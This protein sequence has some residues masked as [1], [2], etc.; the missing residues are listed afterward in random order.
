M[1]KKILSGMTFIVAVLFLVFYL[2]PTTAYQR[3]DFLRLIENTDQCLI[4]CYAIIEVSNPTD[5]D[6]VLDE[7]SWGLWHVKALGARGLDGDLRLQLQE[8]VSYEVEVDDYEEVTESLVCDGEFG[9]KGNMAWCYSANGNLTWNRSFE[10]IIPEDKKIYQTV[11]K[12]VSSHLEKKTKKKYVDFNPAGKTLKPGETY[13]IKILGKKK[14]QVG[15]NNVDWRIR[16]LDFEPDWAWWNSSWG[17]KRPIEINSTS[18]LSDYQ[19]AINVTYDFDMQSDFDDLRFINEEETQ[20]LD[21][22]VESKSDGNWAYVWVEIDSID[23]NNGTQAHMYYGNSGATFKSNGTNTFIQYHGSNSDADFW[24]GVGISIPFIYE[25][26]ATGSSP[27]NCFWGT[28]N[29]E[30]R[31]GDD[32]AWIQSATSTG[33]SYGHSYN[34]GVKTECEEIGTVGTNYRLKIVVTSTKNWFYKNDNE[35]AS[36]ITTNLPNENLGLHMDYYSG[37]CSQTWCFAR[38]YTSPE[39]TYLIGSEETGE[40]GGNA[41]GG[42]IKT[43]SG[44]ITLDPATGI[45]E[46]DGK[47]SMKSP[48]GSWFCCGPN[49]NG[50]WTCS[51]GKCI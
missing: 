42:T 16:F 23:T 21:Y 28:S 24:E 20:E 40:G 51:A 35:I 3:S 45:V 13:R 2:N 9:F 7:N 34:E 1:N 36:G 37:I 5:Q 27:H 44:N 10:A 47:L 48:N 8:D 22:W 49:D 31:G 33:K 41:T 50:T 30:G 32:G 18:N 29:T 46:I 26:L 11:K 15:P 43:T 39:P 14:A 12:K 4:D 17:Y 25:V 6:I 38:K 19:I